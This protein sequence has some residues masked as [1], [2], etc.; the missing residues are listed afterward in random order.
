MFQPIPPDNTPLEFEDTQHDLEEVEF[1]EQIDQ[2]Y[3]Q[4]GSSIADVSED[5]G[6]DGPVDSHH[7]NIPR[8]PGCMD[9][10]MLAN[11]DERN[12]PESSKPKSKKSASC[13]DCEDSPHSDSDEDDT[14]DFPGFMPGNDVRGAPELGNSAT[15]SADST[16]VAE[17]QEDDQTGSS[18]ADLSDEES[19][20]D[21]EG[22]VDSRHTNIPRLP[23]CMDLHTLADI[24]E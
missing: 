19:Q 5:E 12:E 17:N 2:G 3:N 8:V 10:H 13:K 24:D 6:Q 7:P 15:F 11:I 1:E 22:P 14:P 20:D 9:L 4:T 18:I 23:G 21:R 16:L